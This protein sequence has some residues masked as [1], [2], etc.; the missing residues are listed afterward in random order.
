MSAD[1]SA[2]RDTVLLVPLA[3]ET[4]GRVAGL[5]DA[6]R[7]WLERH[8]APDAWRAL[9][10]TLARRAGERSW[11]FR[12]AA[13]VGSGGALHDGLSDLLAERPGDAPATA[14]RFT[15]E[16]L[17]GSRPAAGGRGKLA[18]IVGGTGAQWPG[19]GRS[20]RTGNAVFRGAI[21]DCAAA[22]ARFTGWS[23]HGELDAAPERSRLHEV[24]IGA[25]STFAVCVALDRLLR[26]WGMVPDAIAGHSMGEI[27]G[28]HL[29]GALTLDDAARIIFHWSQV[30]R[31]VAAPG[32]MLV[33][34]LPVGDALPIVAD[35]PGTV[36]IAAIN[37]PKSTTLSGGIAA[38]K[39]IQDHLV[40]CGVLCRML[41]TGGAFHSHEMEPLQE[42]LL[43]GISSIS[44]RAP[45]TAFYT[46]VA[47]EAGEPRFEP[48][49]WWRNLRDTVDL[50]RA[51]GRLSDDGFGQ[52]WE[53]GPH[54]TLA[55]SIADCLEQRGRDGSILG[56]LQR[57]DDD[58]TSVLRSVG[59]FY[60]A[61]GEV[62]WRAM[63]GEPAGALAQLPA[64]E[65]RELPTQGRGD[66]DLRA[67]LA[68]P[69][70]SRGERLSLALIRAVAEIM[71]IPDAAISASDSWVDIGLESLHAVKLRAYLQKQFQVAVPL[72]R[73]LSDQRIAAFVRDLEL[74]LERRQLGADAGTIPRA[75]DLTAADV[76]EM[77][78]AAVDALLSRLVERCSPDELA[79]LLDEIRRAS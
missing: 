6:A 59:A 53:L 69:I 76:G 41:R 47:T 40:A 60:G 37:S 36:S 28:A 51:I 4:P 68:E 71:N 35:H 65:S 73:F 21:D 62:D 3:A 20:L 25:M 5:A 74:D 30:Q 26:S 19:M 32:Q 17:D 33:V 72:T 61:G 50:A 11:P 38:L 55:S 46:T 9:A 63:Y 64:I 29:A 23:L 54:A 48:V 8:D 42:P 24:E 79:V 12:I 67:L 78:A 13:V 43:A 16:L 52:F 77:P 10:H 2:M 56:T 22:F 57:H 49:H 15:G 44:P 34:E 75:A 7:R 58:A 31:L 70:G 39:Q 45:S 1:S 27:V 14:S 18:F 66:L